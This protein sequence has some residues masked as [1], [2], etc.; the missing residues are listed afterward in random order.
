MSSAARKL[1]DVV[2]IVSD[3]R[4]SA[5]GH[6]CER[7][8]RAVERGTSLLRKQPASLAQ[9]LGVDKVDIPIPFASADALLADAD[10]ILRADPDAT[11]TMQCD[12]WRLADA[13]DMLREALRQAAPFRRLAEQ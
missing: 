1:A 7:T 11:F 4:V 8:A 9:L 5:V 12:T 10:R 3:E 13:A 2:G 6:A